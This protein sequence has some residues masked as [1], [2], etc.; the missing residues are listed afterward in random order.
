MRRS[1]LTTSFLTVLGAVAIGAQQCSTSGPAQRAF[2]AGALV[3][4]MDN[5]YQKRDTTTP[6]ENHSWCN[7]TADDGV[8]RA[9]GLVYFLLKHNITVY[10]A[11]DGATPKASLT[12]YDVV[13]PAPASGSVAQHMSWTDGSFTDLVPAGNPVNYLGGPFLV[14]ASDAAAVVS[15]LTNASDSAHAD[16]ARFQS[17]AIVDIHRVQNGFTAPQVRPLSGPPPKI[18]ILNINPNNKKTSVNVMYEYAVAAGLSW[19][20]HGTGDCAGGVTGNGVNNTTTPG[21]GCDLTALYAYLASP[22]GDPGYAQTCDA[23]NNCQPKFN[24]GPGQVYDILCDNDFYAASGQYADTMLAKG[25][26]KLLWAPHWEEGTQANASPAVPP[27]TAADILGTQLASIRGFVNAGNNLFAECHAI[28]TLEGGKGSSGQEYG[29]PITRFQ[30]NNSAGMTEV[31]KVPT[32]GTT[33]ATFQNAATTDPKMQVGDFVYAVV[34]GSVPAYLPDTSSTP[35]YQAGVTRLAYETN[36]TTST[37]TTTLAT[38]LNFDA[39]TSTIITA[40]DGVTKGGIAYLGGHRYYGQSAGTRIVLNTLF[41]L[42]FG[43]SDPNTACTTGLLG[44]C[45]QGVLKCANGGGLSCVGPQPGALDCVTPGADANCN[46]IPDADEQGCQPTA[47]KEGAT[48]SCYDGPAGTAGVGICK[49]GTQTCAGGLWGPCV[50]EVTPQPEVCNGKDDDCDGTVDD[51]PSGGS[52]CDT[53]YS[54][55]NGVCLPVACNSE[56]ARCPTGFTCNNGSCQAN[57]TC[58]AGQVCSGTGNTCVDPCASVACGSGSSCSGGQCVAG[59]CS[60]SGA[61]FTQGGTV[62]TTKVCLDGSCVA[63]PCLA[64][65]CPTGTFCRV[66]PMVGGSYVADCVRSCS[67]VACPSGESCDENGFCEGA[68]SPACPTG[69]VCQAGSC[70]ADPCTGVTCAPN[71][72]CSLGSCID[73]PCL[74]V[75]CP[76]GTCSAGQCTGGQITPSTQNAVPSGSSGKGGGCSSSGPGGLA[77]WCA[78]LLLLALRRVRVPR[79]SAA[80]AVALGAVVLVGAAGCGKGSSA[81]SCSAGQTACGPACVTLASDSNNCGQC[82]RACANGFSCSSGACALATGNPHLVSVSPSTLGLGA[83]PALT[84]T[85]DGLATAPSALSVRLSGAVPAQE[86][87]LTLSGSGTA[88]LP[89]QSMQLNGEAT[90][91]IEVSLLNMPGRLVSNTLTIGVV[92]ALVARTLS[93]ALAQ[94]DQGATLTLDLQG[95]GFISGAVVNLVPSGGTSEALPTTFLSAGELNATVPAP[96]TLDKA[97]YGVTVTNP[98]GATSNALTFTVTDGA[99]NI[100]VVTGTSG[101]CVV[102]SANFAGSVT[103]T[104]LYPDSVV[105]VTGTSNSIVNSPLDTSCLTG[106]AAS[107][108][109]QGGQLRVSADLSAVPAGTYQVTV[110]NPGTTPLVSNALPITVVGPTSTCP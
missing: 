2:A 9:Y 108:Q 7:A 98:G 37:T 96:N 51:A 77:W 94:Q 3:I 60:T 83:S 79:P 81:K 15:M 28:V 41:N 34:T 100:S 73:N 47:C 110:V 36:S 48:Q 43:C 27:T 53:G 20:C 1:V 13:V 59:G 32:S 89:A 70:I 57:C 82:G 45:A 10:W 85:F 95:L 11:I 52:L 64:L 72:V 106:T 101:A 58:P 38:A 63:D 68:C 65:T 4:P 54:C 78:V 30:S 16:F 55:Q 93:P 92:N 17:E 67:Y 8:F 40:P 97:S 102:A 61:C 44:A 26:Y 91:T 18:A 74:H 62:D 88:T 56:N 19:P 50:G 76:V 6:A 80:L 23:N 104:Y 90:G 69:Q 39:A 103:G 33:P 107:G 46:G 71:Q 66:G 35:N 99:P 105:H 24:S 29:L 5:C 75:T 86:L 42:G 31:T 12:G 14:D 22:S 84:F 49:A 109:C 87:P 25:G 21:Q